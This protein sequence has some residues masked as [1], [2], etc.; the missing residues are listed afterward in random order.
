M[1]KTFLLACC[2]A[3]FLAQPS[4][5]Q[6]GF[7]RSC[8]IAPAAPHCAEYQTG[9]FDSRS[10]YDQCRAQIDRYVRAMDEYT[11]CLSNNIDVHNENVD[12][13]IK[14][15]NCRARGENFCP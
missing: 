12:K 1:K 13:I 4:A 3:L 11:Q 9:R 6:Y 2:G 14:R 5:A 7:V 15:F 8:S 10:D